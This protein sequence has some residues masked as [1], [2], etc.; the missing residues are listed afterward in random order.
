[1]NTKITIRNAL[2][3]LVLA[4]SGLFTAG[5]SA[6][7]V[8]AWDFRTDGGFVT[9]ASTC[10]NGPG[11]AACNLTH[12]QGITPSSIGGTATIMTW[13]TGTSLDNG[14]GQQSA[15]QGI[16]GETGEGPY[17]AQNFGGTDPIIIDQFE[18]IVTNGGWTNTGVG[19]HYNNVITL[20][21][22]AMNSAILR[23]SFE[24]TSPLATGTFQTDIDFDFNETE[25]ANGCP[26]GNP[27][28]TM[29]DDVFELGSTLAPI[30]FP[31]MGENYVVQFRIIGGP[32]AIVE[33]GNIIFTAEESP[34][35][36]V[37]YI[38]ARIDAVPVPGVLGLMGLGLVMIGWRTRRRR[39]VV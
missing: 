21:G 4:S 35:T 10:S 26:A 33:D 25:N 30:A 32:G 27:H 9:A 16:F 23:T 38:Q 12:S 37:F 6:A 11:Q 13:G 19:V 36:A 15:L 7:V 24:L 20:A 8:T 18:Q 3:G 17:N 14:N 34:G 2:A 22:G 5:A 39:L 1:M 31:Y 28:G 29:C